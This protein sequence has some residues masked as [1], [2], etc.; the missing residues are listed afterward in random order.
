MAHAMAHTMLT[1]LFYGLFATGLTAVGGGFAADSAMA[2]TLPGNTSAQPPTTQATPGQPPEP[3]SGTPQPATKPAAPANSPIAAPVAPLVFTPPSTGGAGNS[4]NNNAGGNIIKTIKIGGA[5]KIDPQTILSYLP[6]KVGDSWSNDVANDSLRILNST[7]LFALVTIGEANGIV[8]ISIM[9]SPVVDQIAF[10]GN[11]D[12]EDK[13]FLMVLAQNSP[14]RP[15]A[16]YSRAAV[17]KAVNI[18]QQVYLQRGFFQANVTPKLIDIGNNRVQL[19]FV[20]NEGKAPKVG[21]IEF[22][23]NDSF[24]DGSLR[25]VIATTIYNPIRFFA[26]TDQYDPNRIKTDQDNLLRFY[27]DNGFADAAI[28]S[29]TS[30]LNKSRG[31]FTITYGIKEGPRYRVDKINLI[32][33][34]KQ[35]K[36]D[37]LR[38]GIALKKGNYYKISSVEK[39]QRDIVADLRD[40]YNYPFMSVVPK[41][42][43]HPDTGLVDVTFKIMQ[44]Q[45][46]YINR[47]VIKGN[48]RTLDNIIRRKLPITEGDPLDQDAVNQGLQSI[49]NTGYF[50]AVSPQYAPVAGRPD[51]VDLII[52]VQETSTGALNFSAGYS[53]AQGIILGV[54][55]GENNLLGTARVL[56]FNGQFAIPVASGQGSSFGQSYSISYTEP[57]LADKDLALI[58]TLYRTVTDNTASLLTET[59]TGASLGLRFNYNR[60]LSQYVYYNFYFNK[61]SADAGSLNTSAVG[62]LYASIFGYQTSYDTRDNPGDPR[63]GM[64]LTFGNDLAGLGGDV[65][66][67][68]TSATGAGYLKIPLGL[69][70]DPVLAIGIDS[71]YIFPFNNKKVGLTDRFYLGG[72]NLRGFQDSSAGP[73]YSAGSSTSFL[74]GRKYFTQSAELRVPIDFLS[75]IGAKFILFND[76]GILAFPDERNFVNVSDDERLRASWGLGGSFITPVGPIVIS[77]AFP[78]LKGTH[79]VVQ[80]FRLDFKSKF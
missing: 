39:T 22:F 29:A 2:Q 70:N 6:F 1:P 67:L 16:V 17:K 68:R 50:S 4:K 28:L 24:S 46:Q 53:T 74:G 21:A 38:S 26:T 41:T 64:Y 3:K 25:A 5:Q 55:F 40:N 57:F 45:R 7:G 36:I 20:I 14:V 49:Q 8:T 66:Y 35:L 42:T 12:I 47:I 43:T 58:T 15:R 59:R 33:D 79:D 72:A 62:S 78:Y 10:E 80:N 13:D 23:G 18:I 71:G 48:G 52:N 56:T 51:R 19:V 54:T 61:I 32:S 65:Y 69:N 63:S 75:D 44:G 60:Y 73:S 27:Q 11:S 76:I 9:E 77:W 30:Q 31:D 34:I 37:E